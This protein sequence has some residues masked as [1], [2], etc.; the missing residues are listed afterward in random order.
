MVGSDDSFPFTVTGP[1]SGDI[2]SFSRVDFFHKEKK[3]FTKDTEA[4]KQALGLW[5]EATI[6]VRFLHQKISQLHMSTGLK[7]EPTLHM[8][9][10]WVGGGPHNFCLCAAN[11]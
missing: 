7:G 9:N 4:M 10:G 6:R 5:D 1:F 3:H 11:S 2:P 8:G